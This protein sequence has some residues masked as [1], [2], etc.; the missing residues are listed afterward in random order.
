[1]LE[2]SKINII[3]NLDE[4]FLFQFYGALRQ[5]RSQKSGQVD[6]DPNNYSSVT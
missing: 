2:N 4:K 6:M 5:E 1:M 3:Q